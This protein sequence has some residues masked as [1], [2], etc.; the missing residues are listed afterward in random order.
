MDDKTLVA[1]ATDSLQGFEGKGLL[2]GFESHVM[3]VLAQ[4]LQAQQG[5]SQ[6]QPVSAPRMYMKPGATVDVENK[7]ISPQTNHKDFTL[8]K[9][10]EHSMYEVA[11]KTIPMTELK[12]KELSI[13]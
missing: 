10:K 6:K 11:L 2:Q 9:E 7:V 3:K 13:Q 5:N 1:L 8:F 4:R 12:S